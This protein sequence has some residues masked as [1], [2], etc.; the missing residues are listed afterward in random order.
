[1]KAEDL[2]YAIGDVNDEALYDAR[3]GAPM[4]KKG[5]TRRMVTIALAAA[6]LLT[7]GATAVGY[8]SGA[9]WF[10]RY[11]SR[12]AEQGLTDGQKAFVDSHAADIGESVTRNGYTLTLDSIVMDSQRLYVKLMV[13]APTDVDLK[14]AHCSLLASYTCVI[15]GTEYPLVSGGA[16][17]EKYTD[18]MGEPNVLTIMGEYFRYLPEEVTAYGETVS[19]RLRVERMSFGSILHPEEQWTV[20]GPWEIDFTLRPDDF[21][22]EVVTEPFTV[23]VGD[24]DCEWND[25]DVGQPLYG[26]T[27]QTEVR[28]MQLSPLGLRMVST[29]PAGYEEDAMILISLRGVLRDGSTVLLRENFGSW[30]NGEECESRL[31]SVSA[32]M[33]LSELLYIEFEDGTRVEMPSALHERE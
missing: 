8:Y 27:W 23:T 19:C 29:R 14:T 25:K 32:P 26:K 10:A 13:E 7:M 17:D 18:R 22:V 12:F 5:R 9:D 1:M 21:A 11:F 16:E 15:G 28:S 20:E 2:L 31:F 24:V 33:E 30:R 3:F 4:P 6:L